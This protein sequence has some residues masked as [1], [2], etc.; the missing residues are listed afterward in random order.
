MEE[1][2]K[3]VMIGALGLM[4]TAGPVFAQAEKKMTAKP[5]AAKSA[6]SEALMRNEQMMLEALHKKDAAAFKKLVVAGTWA[7]DENGPAVVEEFLKALD[8]PKANFSFEYKTSDMKVVPVNATTSI[9]TY[10]LDEKGGMMGQPFPPVVYASTVWANRGGTW[11][12]V[13]HQESTAAK[14]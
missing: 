8:D 9:V 2:M 6:V 5:M 10:K 11:L 1:R 13:F 12:A 3:H 7:I 14:R 4:L